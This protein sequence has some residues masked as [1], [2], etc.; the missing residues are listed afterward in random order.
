MPYKYP[1]SP[2][3]VEAARLAKRKHYAKN[4]E[5]YIEQAKAKKIEL[6]KYVRNKKNNP[7]M[8][9]GIKYPYYVMQFDHVRGEK[10]K[11]LSKLIS[12][13][14]QKRID[15]ELD[16]CDLV[17]ANCHAIR[18]WKRNNLTSGE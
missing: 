15:E 10:F 8:D 1:N 9:C 14:S 16:K 17:C 4:K 2:E 5:R 18:T 12:H 6:R 7:C 3:A 13:G 11:E